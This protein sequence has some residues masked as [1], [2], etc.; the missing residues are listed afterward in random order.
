MTT[1][2]HGHNAARYPSR[3]CVA[4]RLERGTFTLV[5][6]RAGLNAQARAVF[7]EIAPRDRMRLALLIDREPALFQLGTIHDSQPAPCS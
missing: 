4:C 6:F 3:G 5:Q 1:C 7:N 2:R